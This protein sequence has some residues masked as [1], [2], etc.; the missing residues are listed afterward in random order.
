MK[1]ALFLKAFPVLIM[2]FTASL[3]NRKSYTENVPN[4]LDPFN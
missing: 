2:K 1:Q 4:N 3:I